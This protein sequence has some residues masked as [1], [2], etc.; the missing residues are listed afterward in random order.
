VTLPWWA[1][2]VLVAAALLLVTYR[3][4]R[5]WRAGIREELVGFLDAEAP[6][7][8]VVDVR[9]REIV[10]RSRA[11][12]ERTL[13]LEPLYADAA[14][15]KAADVEGRRQIYRALLKQLRRK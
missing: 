7:L 11:G 12:G 10:V 8:E 13:Q 14:R 3:A 4:G 2:A 1:W 15:L 9:T 6:G 5:T